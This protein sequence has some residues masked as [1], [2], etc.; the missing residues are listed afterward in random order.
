MFIFNG[1]AEGILIIESYLS[2]NFQRGNS[3][4]TL[5]ES[6]R[7]CHKH[8]VGQVPGPKPFST[9][10]PCCSLAGGLFV[11]MAWSVPIPW[12]TAGG[13]GTSP[14]LAGI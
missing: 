9:V 3:V 12:V 2:L 13:A 8:R 14:G 4:L 1:I 7:C 6:C 10:N 5:A 11:E